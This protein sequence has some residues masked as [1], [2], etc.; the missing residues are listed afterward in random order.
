[1]WPAPKLQSSTRTSTRCARVPTTFDLQSAGPNRATTATHIRGATALP[2][3]RAYAP[4]W[5]LGAG[6]GHL[7]G[8]CGHP[9]PRIARPV[10]GRRRHDRPRPDPTRL[11]WLHDDLHL[12]LL[13]PTYG[14]V[15]SS[16]R[17]GTSDDWFVNAI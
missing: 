6:P 2:D 7:A 11:Q 10:G 15:S 17:A 4:C 9:R 1:M 8:A 14:L 12:A 5:A 3:R 13:H 16:Y